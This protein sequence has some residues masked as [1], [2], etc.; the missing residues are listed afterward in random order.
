MRYTK[1][2]IEPIRIDESNSPIHI[3]E[4][5]KKHR[6]CCLSSMLDMFGDCNEEKEQITHIKVLPVGDF[7]I[8][9]D[10]I[11]DKGYF[12]FP[13]DMAY[14]KGEH[15]TD[16]LR[17]MSINKLHLAFMN[18]IAMGMAY[19]KTPP[20]YDNFF[21]AYTD[22]S[23]DNIT[24]H[25]GGWA[26][27]VFKWTN[28]APKIEDAYISHRGKAKD[29]TNN[30]M[31]L[32]AIIDVVKSIPPNSYVAIKSDSMYCIDILSGVEY[33]KRNA[34]LVEEYLNII[35]SRNI[36]VRFQHV[37]GHK[38]NIYNEECDKRAAYK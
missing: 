24:T 33:F 35:T 9:I 8:K 28:D 17:D 10:H 16:V 11:D 29:T 20:R 1:P 36:S 26:N 38:G 23:A 6:R 27:L 21:I 22:G 25:K 12:L 7:L 37:K 4:F 18:A 3:Y 15:T 13:Y 32:T 2:N 31:E 34:D 5:L 14:E 30:R 19:Y